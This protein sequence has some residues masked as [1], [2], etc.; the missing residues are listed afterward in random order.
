MTIA[1]W[2]LILLENRKM[3]NKPFLFHRLWLYED[4]SRARQGKWGRKQKSK[5]WEKKIYQKM[6]HFR[7]N[8]TQQRRTDCNRK[9]WNMNRPLMIFPLY[10]PV[11]RTSLIFSG[12]LL[13]QQH[14]SKGCVMI[15]K[16]A[17]GIKA[18]FFDGIGHLPRNCLEAGAGL[19]RQL[20]MSHW[21]HLQ[22]SRRG[23]KK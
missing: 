1:F 2:D 18:F 6:K 10:L 16:H 23:P 12:E 21:L 8:W 11:S 3:G 22:E 20:G 4:I 19:W 14:I 9:T 5:M 15:N 13:F 17:M 7:R